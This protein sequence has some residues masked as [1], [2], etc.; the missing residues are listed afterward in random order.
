MVLCFVLLLCCGDAWALRCGNKLVKDGMFEI[1]VIELC[2]EPVSVRWLGY[3]LRPYIL[4]QPAGQFGMRSTRHVFSGYYHELA[5]KEML[6]NFGPHRLMQVLRFEGG[7]LRSIET[8]GYGYHETDK[9]PA[10]E[11][12]PGATVSQ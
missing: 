6:F 1:Q 11:I 8:A 3:V 2:G 5:V 7:R 12:A 10:P 4:K 9:R